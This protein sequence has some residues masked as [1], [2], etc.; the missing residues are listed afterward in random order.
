MPSA[1]SSPDD[2]KEDEQIDAGEDRKIQQISPR[3]S[4]DA[5]DNSEKPGVPVSRRRPEHDK[6]YAGREIPGPYIPDGLAFSLLIH[7]I[8]DVGAGE[9]TQGKE[10]AEQKR[11][12]EEGRAYNQ[13]E[14]GERKYGAFLIREEEAEDL[15]DPQGEQR[16]QRDAGQ[17]GNRHGGEQFTEDLP[18]E[19]TLS[20]AQCQKDPDLPGLVPEEE[21]GCIDREH[22]ASQYGDAEDHHDLFRCADRCCFH[23]SS[24]LISLIVSRS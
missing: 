23:M 13:T 19:R 16:S 17:G 10:K 2:K 24:P 7:H 3:R 21:H 1:S 4:K 9:K 18:C 15:P 22:K 14:R 12:G 6:E 11:G 20:G 8:E 5:E